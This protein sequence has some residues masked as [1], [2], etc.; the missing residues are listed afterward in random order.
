MHEEAVG[1]AQSIGG[2]RVY[3]PNDA[4]SKEWRDQAVNQSLGTDLNDG[5]TIWQFEMQQDF[6]KDMSCVSLKPTAVKVSFAKIVG[7]HLKQNTPAPL[8]DKI[9]HSFLRWRVQRDMSTYQ[10]VQGECKNP[11][12]K[13]QKGKPTINSH[14][15]DL[16]NK[17]WNKDIKTE[18]IADLQRALPEDPSKDTEEQFELCTS[19]AEHENVK[20]QSSQQANVAKPRQ[21]RLCGRACSH[22]K[23]IVVT[24]SGDLICNCKFFLRNWYCNN[25]LIYELVEYGVT[26]PAHCRP[27]DGIGYD[28]ICQG[29]TEKLKMTLFCNDDHEHQH[30]K[31]MHNTT[32]TFQRLIHSTTMFQSFT[33]FQCHGYTG[34][35]M[36]SFHWVWTLN[37]R[38]WE[39]A[40]VPKSR[41]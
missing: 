33:L 32:H 21:N 31:I 16:E 40:L 39:S 24:D 7:L 26:P 8:E 29:W 27:V 34:R 1:N 19:L 12:K 41:G 3:L 14:E 38:G 17:K 9:S 30:N 15:Q 11:P 18:A 37:Q 6:A 5:L 28:Q 22:F 2:Y 35:L 25:T 36:V 23:A 20:Q 10:V 13:K 4:F